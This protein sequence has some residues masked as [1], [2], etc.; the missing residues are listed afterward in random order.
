MAEIKAPRKEDFGFHVQSHPTDQPTG[1]LLEGGEEAYHDAV[2][3]HLQ[4]VNEKKT[5]GQIR[6]RTSFNPS[7][8][9]EVDHFKQVCSDAIDK[10]ELVKENMFNSCIATPYFEEKLRLIA[11]AQTLFEDAGMIAVKAVTA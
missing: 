7:A 4:L 3:K 8:D 5:L 11:R 10:L 1:W 2:D 9:S 6:M